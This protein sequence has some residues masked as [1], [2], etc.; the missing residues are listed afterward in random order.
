MK[1]VMKFNPTFRNGR[2]SMLSSSYCSL[3]TCRGLEE[4]EIET[5]RQWHTHTFWPGFISEMK[6]ELLRQIIWRQITRDPTWTCCV[7]VV[8]P[9]CCFFKVNE[10]SHR[11]LLLELVLMSMFYHLFSIMSHVFEMSPDFYSRVVVL[12]DWK[13][14]SQDETSSKHVEQRCCIW[15]PPHRRSCSGNTDD[16]GCS[17]VCVI[18][19]TPAVKCYHLCHCLTSECT[20]FSA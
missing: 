1:W 5:T 16:E 18:N 3:K 14:L 6:T 8:A 10:A 4:P 19:T 12:Q 2:K 9:R 11:L 17:P 7:L 20:L 13:T 15:P